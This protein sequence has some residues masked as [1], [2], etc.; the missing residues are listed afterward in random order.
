MNGDGTMSIETNMADREKL[1]IF[2]SNKAEEG[3][4]RMSQQ[5]PLYILFPEFTSRKSNSELR[6][7]ALFLK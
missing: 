5:T 2:G 6:S 3:K 1:A 7:L 4:W